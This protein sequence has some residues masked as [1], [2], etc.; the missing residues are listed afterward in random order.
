V[1]R[2]GVS[3]V[4]PCF[5]Y[6]RFLGDCL[7]SIFALE[8]DHDLEVIAIDDAST[9]DTPDILRSF[10]DPRLRVIT[11]AKNQG[12]IVTINEG[13]SE[14]RGELV[15]RIDAD[16]RYRPCFLEA[17]VP[18]LRRHPEVG[19]V[20]GDAAMID[21]TGRVTLA[22]MDQ[23]HGGRDHKG[24]EL[25]T[26]LEKNIVCA[27]TVLARRE[28]WQRALPIPAGLAFSDWYFTLEI[29][30]RHEVYF[31]AQVVADYRVHDRNHHTLIARNRTEEGSIFRLL[32]GIY[33]APEEDPAL[34]ARKQAARGRVYAAHHLDLATK[35]FGFGERAQARRSY[36]AALRADPVLAGDPRTMRRLL[37]TWLPTRVYEGLKG[38]LGRRA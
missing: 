30:R 17:T 27:P 5:N 35:Y 1:K 26:F 24:N 19:M 6:G 14:A 31:V 3:I 28:A 32:D 25:I 23:V 36:L 34:E 37:A 4:V 29:A 38:A 16:D 13:L 21:S 8:G 22:S 18:P 7:R 2:P 15:A 20:Y 9:D 10:A 12:H 33:A 11:H